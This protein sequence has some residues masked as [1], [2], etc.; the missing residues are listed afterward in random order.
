MVRLKVI[1]TLLLPSVFVLLS[2]GCTH[3][4]EMDNNLEEALEGAVAWYRSGPEMLESWW[5]TAALYGAGED[6]HS[7]RWSLP[8]RSPEELPYWSPPTDYAV[9]V[10]GLLAGGKDPW[11]WEGRNLVAELATLQQSDGSFGSS[12]NMSIW[13]VIALYTAGFQYEEEAAL[14][15]LLSRQCKDGGF[16]LDPGGGDPDLTAMALIA[17][18]FYR[19]F[20]GVEEGIEK[21]LDFLEKVRLPSGGYASYGEENANSCAVVLSALVALGETAGS[22]AG[23]LMDYQLPDGSFAYRKGSPHSDVMAT[24][25]SAMA[26]GD[27]LAG[28]TVFARLKEKGASL[29][30]AD[31]S[32]AQAKSPTAQPGSG[33]LPRG[34]VVSLQAVCP[35]A[36]IFYSLDG[37]SPAL[38]GEEYTGPIII[39][40]DS[41][42]KAQTAS[43]GM[44]T[45]ETAEFEYT[46]LPGGKAPDNVEQKQQPPARR[47]PDSSTPSTGEDIPVEVRVQ[48]LKTELFS[49]E[50]FLPAG[51][52]SAL[53]ALLATGLEVRLGYGG[54]FVQ[55][56]E[57]EINQGLAGWKYKVGGR[58]SFLP[59]GDYLLESGDSVTWWYALSPEEGGP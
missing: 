45:S 38:E 58:D 26:L 39:E 8:E 30:P 55:G 12:L 4:R 27:L 52:A 24:Y 29:R 19:H 37:S 32:L 14:S 47:D 22:L 9:F 42:L 28:E 15:F 13:A 35:G 11:D 44:L 16:S 34:T 46:V 54:R 36:R 31:T 21:A 1:A 33:S 10:I 40:E 49:G 5:E 7:A 20:D 56:V 48:G 6:L 2:S 51:E 3:N 50:V 23:V 57:G 43:P 53:S 59:A 41:V 18:S 17:L 25:Q